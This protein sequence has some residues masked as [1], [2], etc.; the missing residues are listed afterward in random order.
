MKFPELTKCEK[1]VMKCIWRAE[2]D[3]NAAEIRKAL[4]EKY[5][6]DYAPT[7]ISTFLFHLTKKGY[8]EN[9]RCGVAYFYKPRI[10]EKDYI[11]FEMQE[12]LDF[13]MDGSKKEWS[14]MTEKLNGKRIER[15]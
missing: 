3:I 1:M 6:K 10:E 11:I 9:Y 2:K 12:F 7:T 4:K 8:V 15:K 14:A 5:Q 13:W